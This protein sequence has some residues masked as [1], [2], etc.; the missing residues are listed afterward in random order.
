MYIIKS[1]L[2]RL[3]IVKLLSKGGF[4]G[5]IVCNKEVFSSE[6][7]TMKLIVSCFISL[8]L[9]FNIGLA[10]PSVTLPDANNLFKENALDDDF[11]RSIDNMSTGLSA[12]L[13]L[14]LQ[15]GYGVAIVVTGIFAVKILLAS[16]AKK[17]EVKASLTPYFLG[18]LLLIAGV[19]IAVKVIEIYT[20]IF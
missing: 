19:T 10:A 7:V 2:F 13:T 20:Q 12:L 3:F 4:Y 6:V 8:M 5:I 11:I 9:I 16:P 1:P 15:V 14:V 18:L 17:A